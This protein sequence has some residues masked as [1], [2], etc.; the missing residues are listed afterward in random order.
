M[1]NYL[2]INQQILSLIFRHD[3]KHMQ[4]HCLFNTLRYVSATTTKVYFLLS[5]IQIPDEV[6]ISDPVEKKEAGGTRSD[7]ALLRLFQ[8]LLDIRIGLGHLNLI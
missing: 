3:D 6:Y 7:P 5:S 1:R 8:Q 2:S 4:L